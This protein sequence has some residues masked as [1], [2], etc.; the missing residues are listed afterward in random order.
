MVEETQQLQN[1]CS[2]NGLAFV[3]SNNAYNK[4]PY[5]V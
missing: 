1:G 2:A 5:S 3:P 4:N